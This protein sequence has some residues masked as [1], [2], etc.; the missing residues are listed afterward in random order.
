MA[1]KPPHAPRGRPP[2]VPSAAARGHGEVCA[3]PDE[4]IRAASLLRH[5]ERAM[6]NLYP[7]ATRVV[8]RQHVAARERE[9]DGS[10]SNG[11]F[12]GAM[13]PVDAAHMVR[14]RSNHEGR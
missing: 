4:M 2:M 7:H 9:G 10:L 8:E 12:H 11:K 13:M 14:L 5:P 3:G 6:A 1:K